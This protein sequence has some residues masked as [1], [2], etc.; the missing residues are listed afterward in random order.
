M[1]K[2]GFETDDWSSTLFG[3]IGRGAEIVIKLAKDF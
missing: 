1:L 2:S 3:E